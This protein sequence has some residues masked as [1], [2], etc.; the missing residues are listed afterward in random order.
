[1]YER[2]YGL[3]LLRITAMFMVL[4][5]HILGQGGILKALPPPET[6]IHFSKFAAAWLVEIFAYCA[7]NCYAILTGYNYFGK[8]IKFA[9]IMI[10]WLQVLFY[11]TGIS[12]IFWLSGNNIPKN[13]WLA[14]LL[15]VT[16]GVYWYVTAYFGL[17][18]L[19]PILNQGLVGVDRQKLKRYMIILFVFVSVLPTLF[20]KDPYILN[21]GYSLIWLLL[22]FLLGGAIRKLDVVNNVSSV[23]AMKMFFTSVIFTWIWKIAFDIL[24]KYIA[25]KINPANIF[26]KYTSPTII[27]SGVF[28][29]ILFAKIKVSNE[30]F[31]NLI[32][33]FAPAAFGIYLIHLHPLIWK[34]IF[35]GFSAGFIKSHVLMMLAKILLSAILIYLSCT[36]IEIIRIKLFHYLK[37]EEKI[38]DV[39]N[40]MINIYGNRT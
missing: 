33:F 36:L 14:S 12:L 24:T 29:F 7:V 38:Q 15:P 21:R 19:M 31:K 9:K 2:N 13:I 8:A 26:I 27:F 35:R 16:Y 17:F 40:K 10:F 25:L 32:K 4:L 20:M 37:V 39:C 28:L 5:L 6:K 1:M 11:T 23:F 30:R 34:G 22:L 3:D 18:L